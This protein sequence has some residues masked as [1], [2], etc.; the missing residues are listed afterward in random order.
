MARSSR[1]WIRLWWHG[2][3]VLYYGVLPVLE[4]EEGGKRTVGINA[5]EDDCEEKLEG[6]E[7]ERDQFVHGCDGK[8]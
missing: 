5:Q 8:G 4:M 1:Y 6:A 7:D 2:L 3:L